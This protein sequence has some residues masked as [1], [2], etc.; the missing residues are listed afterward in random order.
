NCGCRLL[1]TRLL[2][3]KHITILFLVVVTF[4]CASRQLAAQDPDVYAKLKH[5]DRDIVNVTSV[6]FTPDGMNLAV[7]YFMADANP[8][9]NKKNAIAINHTGEVVLWEV[10][11]K[12]KQ[13]V[14][15]CGSG[16]VRFVAF[17]PDGKFLA[18]AHSD[19][20][21]NTENVVILE[22]P[23]RKGHHQIVLKQTP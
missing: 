22:M 4:L 2:M 21:N 16:S 12:K 17:S 15:D 18:I 1:E 6:A 10:A 5:G 3:F 14:I 20:K 8:V 11:T 9:R 23:S 19:Y 7:G 13:A